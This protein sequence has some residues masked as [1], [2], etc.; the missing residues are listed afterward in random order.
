M[1]AKPILLSGSM[2]RALLAGN[3]TQTRRVIKNHPL[4]DGG[5]T[6]DYI[7]LPENNVATDCKYGNPGDYLWVRETWCPVDDSDY[8]GGEWV[9]YRATPKYESS[10]PAGWDNEPG[11]PDALKWRPSIHMPRSAS[12]L[13]LCITDIR[14]ERLQEISEEDAKAEGAS[15]HDGH[16]V[17]HS[18]WR[19]DF[20]GVYVNPR[21]A[22]AGLWI[23]IYGA[24][25]WQENPWV[26]VIK[27][28]VI[29]QNIDNVLREVA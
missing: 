20:G 12:R 10:H 2:V 22:F 26:W 19:I 28:T 6:D 27:F 8:D 24:E 14:V 23:S 13:T 1:N 7:K 29:K 5:F 9:D 21:T 17:G 16:G 3:K 15:F 11:S 25:S 4:I 18:G